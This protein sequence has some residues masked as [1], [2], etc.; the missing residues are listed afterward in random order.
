[1]VRTH[2]RAVEKTELVAG[3]LLATIAP[4]IGGTLVSILA[5]VGHSSGLESA[6]GEVASPRRVDIAGALAAK[7]ERRGIELGNV[8]RSIGFTVVGDLPIVV[9]VA[10]LESCVVD[11]LSLV[12]GTEEIG[13]HRT[14]VLGV[15][16]PLDMPLFTAKSEFTASE[17][18]IVVVGVINT[19]DVVA[20]TASTTST[21]RLVERLM[22][23]TVTRITIAI[24]VTVSVV[25]SVRA[26]TSRRRGNV[27]VA[28]GGSSEVAGVGGGEGVAVEG[29]NISTVEVGEGDLR[30]S[31]L[32]LDALA[33]IG[34][35][36]LVPERV[37]L[38]QEV[39]LEA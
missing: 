10:I 3:S 30:A 35:D 13:T 37:S 5:K 21:A 27:S 23:A 19:R 25:A 11:V 20:V 15:R 22:L 9:D 34:M 6:G 38:R 32:I 18:D 4:S 31:E 2:E 33:T 8:V 24:E 1:V 36:S 14:N 28:L 7:A 17:L 12:E 39:V 29:G 16:V 26:E